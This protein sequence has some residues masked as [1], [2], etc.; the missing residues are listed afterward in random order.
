[1]TNARDV[2][3]GS[4]GLMRATAR[5][6]YM[7]GAFAIVLLGCTTCS[8]R[9]LNNG[10]FA[11]ASQRSRRQA[12]HKG[13][14]FLDPPSTCTMIIKSRNRTDLPWVHHKT[15]VVQA[16]GCPPNVLTQSN[17]SPK[18]MST[19]R[20]SAALF[21]VQDMAQKSP[22]DDGVQYTN[23]KIDTEQGLTT[24]ITPRQGIA[25]LRQTC[26]DVSRKMFHITR[27]SLIH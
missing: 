20:T 17:K 13:N 10:S 22:R 23:Q 21:N 24:L 4:G 15:R 12:I 14:M 16:L 11:S 3:R 1:M 8:T 25:P 5:T 26:S 19:C 6:A 27:I 9:A 18:D 7:A 2:G